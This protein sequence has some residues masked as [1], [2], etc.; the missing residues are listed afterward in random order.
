MDESTIDKDQ[1]GKFTIYWQ[2]RFLK[3]NCIS[4]FYKCDNFTFQIKFTNPKLS[5]FGRTSIDCKFWNFK[6]YE[7]DIQYNMF[8]INK[9]DPENEIYFS[10]G[11]YEV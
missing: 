8:I 6:Y 2:A 7:Y 5:K 10:S 1:N 11:T 4:P 9:N 3:D